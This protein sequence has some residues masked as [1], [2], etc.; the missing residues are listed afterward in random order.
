MTTKTATM[1]TDK[2]EGKFKKSIFLPSIIFIILVTLYCAFF[3]NEA[4]VSLNLAKGW[5]FNNFSWFYVLSVAFFIIFLVLISGSSLGDI[6]LGADSEQAQYPYLSWVAMLFAAGMGIGL[7]FFGVAEP[8]QHFAGPLHTL[9]SQETKV[10]EAMMMSFLH[11]GFHAWAIYAIVGLAL[12]YFGFR[13][14][15]PLTIRSSFYPLLKHRINGFWGHL[16]DVIALCSTVL[17]ISTTIGFGAMQLRAGLKAIGLTDSTSFLSLVI[18][19]FVML[20]IATISAISGVG[21][22]VRRLSEINLGLAFGLMLFVFLAGDPIHLLAVFSD[23]FGYYLKNFVDLTFRTFSYEPENLPWFNGWT[24]LYWAWWVSWA[25]FVGLFIAKISR[26]RTIR[27]FVLGVL[28]VPSVFIFLWFTIFG[29]TAIEM[30]IANGG[31]LSAQ[32]GGAEGMLFSFFDHLPFGGFIA[33]VISVFIIT[34][35]FVTSADSGIFVINNIALQGADSKSKLQSIFWAVLLMAIS[36]SL[37]FT[38]GLGALQTMTLI[39]SLPFT[40]IIVILCIGLWK[41]LSVDKKYFSTDVNISSSSWTADGWQEKLAKI[42]NQTQRK[43]MREFYTNVAEPAFN[44]L[45][46][47]FEANN[48][49]AK[50]RLKSKEGVRHFEISIKKENIHNFLYG[51]RFERRETSKLLIQDDSLPNID[52]K[53]IYEPITYFIDGREGYDIQYMSKDELIIDVLKQYERYINLASDDSHDLIL[54]D[55][56]DY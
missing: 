40:I 16:I 36:C 10:K 53:W 20:L 26:G 4:K 5:I 15:L 14:K 3:P 8:M 22:G 30:D 45:K 43:D 29:N 38:D 48:L 9:A 19:I 55:V 42:V 39:I 6:R 51:I 17:G 7:M 41:G 50:I 27:E 35:F 28:L 25:P 49:A 44:E 1:G 56:S 32:A 52:S 23:N 13:Y 54:S 12:A 18:I 21:K 46:K 37:L 11:W 31:F 24:V 33:S 2:V 34:L 47:E